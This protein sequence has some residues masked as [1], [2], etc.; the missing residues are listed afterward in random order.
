M[1]SVHSLNRRT[2]ILSTLCL[3]LFVCACGVVPVGIH[4]VDRN[5]TSYPDVNLSPRPCPIQ[6]GSLLTQAQMPANLT[7]QGPPESEIGPQFGLDDVT[8][9]SL[10]NSSAA[11]QSVGM[12]YPVPLPQIVEVAEGIVLYGSVAAAEQSMS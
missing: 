4:A 10:G 5:T 7:P 8:D 3:S 9:G 11:F 2:G 12:P 6:T 1:Q